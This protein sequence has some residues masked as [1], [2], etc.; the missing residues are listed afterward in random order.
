MAK[1]ET[2]SVVHYLRITPTEKRLWGARAR[3]AGESLNAWVR[4][5][6][7]AKAADATVGKRLCQFADP[8]G[9]SRCEM[10]ATPYSAREAMRRGTKAYCADHKGG[11]GP[12]VSEPTDDTCDDC[13]EVV[14]SMDVDEHYTLVCHVL[15]ERDSERCRSHQ[16]ELTTAKERIAE[17]ESE[18]LRV[19]STREAEVSIANAEGQVGEAEFYAEEAQTTRDVLA[20]AGAKLLWF[21]AAL[22]MSCHDSGNRVKVYEG[23]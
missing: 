21:A 16:Q 15:L 22:A 23:P 19:I 10:F 7:S 1:T 5:A 13:G 9:V 12:T 18:L 4:A 6:A 11:R 2:M 3:V 20:K 14:S 8:D 17:L